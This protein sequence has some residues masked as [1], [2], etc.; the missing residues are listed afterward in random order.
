MRYFSMIVVSLLLGVWMAPA[1]PADAGVYHVYSCRAPSG[2]LAPTSGWSGSTSGPWMYDPNGCAS[3]G[4]LTAALGGNVAQPANTS[5]AGWTFSAPAGTQIAAARLWRSASA[6]S[7]EAGNNSTVTWLSAP[8]DGYTSANVFDQCARFQG[9]ATVG[10]PAAPMSNANLVQAPPGNLSGA[11]HIYMSAYCGGTSGT[12]CPAIG[13][14]YS[15]QISLYAADITVAD[16]SPPTASSIGGSL[17]ASG[18]TSGVGDISFSATDTGSGLYEAVFLVDGRAV[19]KQLLNGGSGPCRSVGGTTDGSNAFFE[20][21]PCPLALSD[22]LAFDTSLAP[23]GSHLLA[24]QLLDAAGNATTILNRQVTFANNAASLPTGARIGPG[25]PLALRGPANGT[26]ASDQPNLT[27]RWASTSRTLRTSRY[28]A[29][30]TITGRLTAPGGVGIADASL[31]VYETPAYE[32]A[33]TVF[34]SAVRTGGTGSWTM[35][36]PRGVSS[37]SLRFEYRSHQNDTIPV[38]AAAL[39][40][41]VHAGIALKITP[42]SA[43][44]GRRI[45]FSGVL[46]GTPIP[47]GGKQLV[48]EASSGGEWIQF[49]TIRTNVKGRYRSSYRFKFPGP[50]SYKFRVLSR[51]EAD[52]PFVDGA[53]NVVDV[54]EH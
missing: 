17:A 14:G 12:S 44:V 16:D 30:D 48:L 23:D 29:A 11:T 3:G 20:V 51:Y 39:T 8:E 36:L 6:N 2:S 33:R 22:D 9:C 40:L 4:S 19:S 25:S 10:D 35:T 54:H 18:T 47:L 45:F 38:A 41:R 13:G 21:E 5:I 43:S 34:L 31:G 32:G 15:V 28:R 24:V 7:W 52:F 46:H 42:R 50:A 53:S 1:P 37:S 49:D 26:N 27:A